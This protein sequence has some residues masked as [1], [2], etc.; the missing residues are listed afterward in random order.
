MRNEL[1]KTLLA[2]RQRLARRERRTLGVEAQD[3]ASEAVLR[4]LASPPPDGN[5]APWMERIFKNLMA[6]RWRRQRP[7]I[8]VEDLPLACADPSAEEQLLREEQ[9][10]LLRL[11]LAALP[12]DLGSALSLRVLEGQDEATVG[13]TL[14]IAAATVRSRIHRAMIRL[15]ENVVHLRAIFPFPFT[16]PALASV[17]TTTLALGP[18]LVALCLVT[19]IAP[20]DDYVPIS[21]D[22]PMPARIRTPEAH[23][24]AVSE[25]RPTKATTTA[26]P[27][28]RGKAG[29]RP[30]VVSQP[31][32]A[33]RPMAIEGAK[34]PS[35]ILWP[36]ILLVEALTPGVATAPMVEIPED[37]LPAF[38]KMI[39]ESL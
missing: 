6:D 13:A 36:D 24:Q 11:S 1:A 7:E 19:T 2:Q 33:P 23:A 34:E 37:F 3:L 15:R 25:D 4:T 17:H 38:E 26:L 29:V 8:T 12:P 27:A 14:G 18:I 30:V 28:R 5:V 39:E 31:Q 21:A 9:T 10:R 20:V 35:P 16:Q 32:A 22:V